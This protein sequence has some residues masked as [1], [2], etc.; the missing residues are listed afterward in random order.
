M[1]IKSIITTTNSQIL[2]TKVI[3]INIVINFIKQF[4]SSILQ[5]S[6]INYFKKSIIIKEKLL[7]FL[8]Y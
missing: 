4:I 3:K 5:K 6:F 1:I 8:N 2:F 7:R